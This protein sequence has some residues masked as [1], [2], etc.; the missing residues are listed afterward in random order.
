MTSIPMKENRSMFAGGPSSSIGVQSYSVGN[1]IDRV[2]DYEL[3]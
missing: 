3:N 1:G 2:P